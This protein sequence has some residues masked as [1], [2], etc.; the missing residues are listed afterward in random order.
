VSAAS[1]PA[2]GGGPLRPFYRDHDVP[3][4]SVR[5]MRTAPEARGHPRGRIEL[6]RCARCASITNTAF[7]PD[8][9][10]YGRDYE[11]TQIYS[12]VFSA[13]QDQLVRSLIDRFGLRG[14]HIVEI[15]CGKGAFLARLCELGGNT[16]TGYDPAA[17]AERLPAAARGRVEIVRELFAEGHGPL[18]AECVICQMTLEHI[19]NVSG[20]LGAAR[21][22]LDGRPGTPVLFQVPDTRRIL[23]RAAF[24]DVYHEHCSYF[25]RESLRA[26]F[27]RA[28]F[29]VWSCETV[30]H[31]QYVALS[32]TAS[33]TPG[34]GYLPGPGTTEA[35]GALAARFAA[36]ADDAVEHWRSVL[37]RVEARGG[38]TA[39]WGGG[40]KA[41]AF[42][43]RIDPDARVACVVDVNPYK[44]GR[45]LPGGG[46]RIVGPA[47]LPEHAP[48]LVVVMN[49]AYYGE[50]C[51]EL[52][53]MGLNA[54]VMSMN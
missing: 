6:A 20:F 36:R 28:G 26:A 54:D 38:S 13:F 18:D 35:M 42:L 19:Q 37:R 5:L 3:A 44:Q 39:V 46:H 47:Q 51:A 24:W 14:R 31:D 33:G 41:V 45:Y 7:A 15:G 21:R 34:T 27:V 4:H 49:A 29:E 1:C 8:L 53:R 52:A 2:C 40:S 22:A 48:A 11:E 12:P 17:S 43:H 32:A 23:E 9:M 10:D 50:V 16:G 30:Y 25:T